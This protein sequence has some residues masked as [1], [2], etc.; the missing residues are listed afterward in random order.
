MRE[1]MSFR[2]IRAFSK[3]KLKENLK[4]LVIIELFLIVISMG[5][6]AWRLGFSMAFPS[7]LLPAVADIVIYALMAVFAVGNA[8][9]CLGA[10]KGMES[11]VDQI[12]YFFKNKTKQFLLLIFRKF[13]IVFLIT[14]IIGFFG[15][16]LFYAATNESF[17][18]MYTIGSI[19]AVIVVELRYFPALYLLLEDEEQICRKAIWRGNDMMRGNYLRLIGFWIS[20]VPWMV[21]GLIPCGLGLLVVTP[22]YQVSQAVFYADLKEQEK[23]KK[24]SQAGEGTE[25]QSR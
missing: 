21:L 19:V 7:T 3:E 14:F 2:E 5:L 25:P 12:F 13:I 22:W 10:S 4:V 1:R 6:G 9:A 23:M 15:D 24:R 18:Y 16:L 11:R 20:F 17:L 8:A